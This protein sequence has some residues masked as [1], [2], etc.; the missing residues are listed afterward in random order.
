MSKKKKGKTSS[1][2]CPC[3]DKLPEY[4]KEEKPKEMV[5]LLNGLIAVEGKGSYYRGESLQLTTFRLYQCP[6]CQTYYE[7]G[8]HF[9]SDPQSTMGLYREEDDWWVFKRLEGKWIE[10]R[11]KDLELD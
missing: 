9:W 8:H 2:D 3:C 10:K 6:E 5:E 1:H 11:L 7:Y 4:L